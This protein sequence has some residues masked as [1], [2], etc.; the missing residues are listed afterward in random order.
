MDD[1]LSADCGR[2]NIGFWTPF[3]IALKQVTECELYSE[4]KN[5]TGQTYGV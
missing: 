5:A 4:I 2:K 1:G 3:K